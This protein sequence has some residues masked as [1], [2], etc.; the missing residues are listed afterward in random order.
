MRTLTDAVAFQVAEDG[1]DVEQATSYQRFVLDLVLQVIALADRNGVAIDPVLRSRAR[2]MLEAVAV[3][4][5]PNGRAPRIGD[6]DRPP[7]SER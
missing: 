3:L 2:A 7:S 1:I 5:G 4:V 6:H